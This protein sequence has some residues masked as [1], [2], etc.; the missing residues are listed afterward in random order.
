LPTCRRRSSKT[1]LS[2]FVRGLAELGWTDGRNIRMDIRWAG[3][4]VERM[5]SLAKELIELQPDVILS[6]TTGVTFAFHRETRTIPIVFASVSD[7][8]G[9]GFVAGLP[10]PGGNFTGF[11]YAEGAI[12]GKWLASLDEIA[13]GVKRAAFMFNPGTTSGA[14]AYFLPSFEIAARTLKVE[15]IAAPVHSDG[16]VEA[17]MT[18]LAREPRSGLVVV[19][20]SFAVVH[21]AKIISLAAENNLPTIY[22]ASVFARDGGLLSYGP[23]R[24][25]IFHRSA[26]YVDWVLRGAKPAELPVEVPTKF[27]MVINITTAKTLGL[28]IPETLLATADEVIQ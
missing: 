9:D 4:N 2:A 3:G 25:D 22:S 7:P 19:G 8:V 27:E 18:S 20:D 26:T 17:A 16:E 28:T 15:A 6:P 24:A 10:R 14:G 12:A 1:Y 21:R 11:I 5:N 23:D 13:N